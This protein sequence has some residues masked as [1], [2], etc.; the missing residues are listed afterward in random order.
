M[1]PQGAAGEQGGGMLGMKS[2]KV[3]P[4]LLNELIRQKPENVG[5]TLREW[6]GQNG[7]N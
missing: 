1:V 7:G 6:L 2:H 4:E 5:A 3:S